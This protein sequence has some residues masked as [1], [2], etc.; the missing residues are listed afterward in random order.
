MRGWRTLGGGSLV[1]SLAIHAIII[2]AAC[3]IVFTVHSRHKPVDF[4]PRDSTIQAEAASQKAKNTSA[5]KRLAA[6][7]QRQ[8]AARVAIE[9]PGT[10]TLPETPAL[11]L[12]APDASGS[13]G[14][15]LSGSGL[16]DVGGGRLDFGTLMGRSKSSTLL[17]VPRTMRSRCSA[18]E[19]IELLRQNG[20]RPE[21]EAAVSRSLAWL[22]TQQNEDGSWGRANQSAMTGLV[23]LC[24]LGRCE[25]PDSPFYG[26]Q[27]TKGILHL[28][29]TAR[30]NEHGFI[31]RDLSGSAGAY[32]HGIATYAL[33]EMY[34]LAR[35]GT[36]SLPGLRETF[37]NGVALII[38][39]QNTEAR[40]RGSWDYYTRNVA[41]GRW[42]SA[43]QDLSV[44]GWQYQALKAA[45]NT[46]L[47]ID[48]LHAAIDNC[49]K[50]LEGLQTKDGGFGG[51]QRDA[52][53]NQWSLSATA[54]LGMQT[55]GRG[56]KKTAVNKGM[57]F[58]RE[59]IA[60]EPLD[61]NTNCNLYSWY[62]LTQ[63]FFQQGGD[64]W[65]RYN[66]QLLPQIL[67]SQNPD[68]SWRPGRANWPPAAAADPIYRQ[69]LCTLQLEVY[70]RYLKVADRD[71]GSVFDR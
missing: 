53:Y 12:D 55:L 52:A 29:E 67:S 19:R 15:A 5:V 23:L 38:K 57:K 59:F 47:K 16:R 36:K 60:A 11:M 21:C 48:G 50:Y 56:A 42:T 2:A 13:A 8:P 33:G 44:S 58:L 34:A 24:Y 20:G 54:V 14:P 70:Y 18:A 35:L 30:T 61:W 43:R 4:I 46:G 7:P 63:A 28:I 27:V 40:A 39:T 26:D 66:E 68:G 65:K 6:L 9:R 3:A 31:T 22:K 69:V 1:F 17:P 71:E 37:E 51:T 64:D 45:K 32:E 10:V 62:Y 41:G 25:T 49:V